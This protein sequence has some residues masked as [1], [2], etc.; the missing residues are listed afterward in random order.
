MCLEHGEGPGTKEALGRNCVCLLQRFF[1]LR[2]SEISFCSRVLPYSVTTAD[3]LLLSLWCSPQEAR[4]ADCLHSF[5]IEN[6]HIFL[7]DMP[8]VEVACRK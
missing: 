2:I 8:G 7:W 5:F 3:F 6:I 4:G 1:S